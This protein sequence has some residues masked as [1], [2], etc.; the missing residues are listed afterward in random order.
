MSLEKL[1]VA[2]LKK[3]GYMKQRQKDLFV[4][5]L[6]MPCG[7]VTCDQLSGISRITQ[8]YGTGYIHIAGRVCA[9]SFHAREILNVITG[10]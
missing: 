6:R 4:V 1:D 7:N 9:I 10:S 5:R 8:K 3:S 2:T